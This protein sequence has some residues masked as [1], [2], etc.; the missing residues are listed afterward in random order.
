MGS[1]IKTES[2]RICGTTLLTLGSVCAGIG[3]YIFSLILVWFCC[4][5]QTFSTA[6]NM[7]IDNA[8]V[9]YKWT[10]EVR[11]LRHPLIPKTKI[12]A[13]LTYFAP[14]LTYISPTLTAIIL[15]QISRSRIPGDRR[16][17]DNMYKCICV[18][19]YEPQVWAE[20][21][22]EILCQKAV[23]AEMR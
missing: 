13:C 16:F 11:C 15:W 2:V 1:C 8:I 18:F 7:N 23:E 20:Q 14:I 6:Q 19:Y 9:W 5:W 10:I 21:K 4:G 3:L 17:C 22:H 12:L